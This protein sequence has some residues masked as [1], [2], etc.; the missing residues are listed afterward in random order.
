[1]TYSFD[2]H[3]MTIR[4]TSNYNEKGSGANL[5]N[6]TVLADLPKKMFMIFS[7]NKIMFKT[8]IPE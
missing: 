5:L 2:R 6:I 4:C 8:Y 3:I 1:M 7:E